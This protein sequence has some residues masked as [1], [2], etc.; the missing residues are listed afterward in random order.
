MYVCRWPDGKPDP[1]WH[2]F[3]FLVSSRI[4]ANNYLD[5]FCTYVGMYIHTYVHTHT[6]Q[7]DVEL[8]SISTIGLNPL[9]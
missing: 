2:D 7:K 5:I 8:G 3:H 1:E 4:A 9:S 6:H